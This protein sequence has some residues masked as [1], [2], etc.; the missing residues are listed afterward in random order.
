MSSELDLAAA[1]AQLSELERLSE[2]WSPQQREQLAA[3]RA[4]EQNVQA[5]AWRRFLRALREHPEL[6][7]QPETLVADEW[8][9]AV[10][11]RLGVLRASLDERIAEAL[12]PVRPLLHAHGGDVEVV[13]ILPPDTVHVR[14]TGSC[15]GC[16][17]S[18]VTLA[19]G[20]VRAIRSACPEIRQV[21]DISSAAPLRDDAIESP[22]AGASQGSSD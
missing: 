2:G 14:L 3:I 1:L 17:A 11:R 15:E 6:A 20:V 13:D 19:A 18:A 12:L 21:L 16:P 10:L 7:S 8:I 9:Y 4:Q 22:F 5:E